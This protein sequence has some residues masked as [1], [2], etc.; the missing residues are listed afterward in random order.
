M[1][2]N[3]YDIR[4]GMQQI[5]ATKSDYVGEYENTHLL[6]NLKLMDESIISLPQI[7]YLGFS[8]YSHILITSSKLDGSL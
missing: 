1:Y 4:V 8:L 5:S 6:N 2:G 3:H 7:R